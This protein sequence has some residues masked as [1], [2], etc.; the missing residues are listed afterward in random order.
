MLKRL[1]RIL[2]LVLS[3]VA[4]LLLFLNLLL[5]FPSIQ[6][7]L[8]HRAASYLSA[9]LHAKVQVGKVDFEFL[10]KL[11]L[12]DVYV[13]DLHKDTLLY[14]DA[15]RVD[16]GGLDF[17]KH[18]LI[19]SDLI[20][21]NT[22]FKV[23]TYKGERY[24]NIQF[25][26]DFFASKDTTTKAPGPKWDPK[27]NALTL[28]N[29]YFS[30]R[31][32]YLP[33]SDSL[34]DGAFNPGDM[35]IHNINGRF[36]DIQFQGDTLRG[37][38]ERLAAR[39]ESGLTLKNLNCYVKLSSRKMELDA[40]K[41]ETPKSTLI[42]DL[43]FNYRKFP[44]F[45]DFLNKVDMN[46]SFHESTLSFE[47]L[48]IFAPALKGVHN[49]FIIS[50]DYLG[51][52]SHLIGHNMKISWGKFSSFEGDA[53][54]V[55]LPDIMKT[56]IDVDVDRLV[57][58]KSELEFLPRPPF[59][60]TDHISLPDNFACLK[61]VQLSGSFKGYVYDF[62]ASGSMSSGIGKIFAVLSMKQDT[63]ANSEKVYYKG[64]LGTEAFDLGTFWQSKD[65]GTVTSSVTIEG[66]GLKREN[67]DAQLTGTIES[68]GFKK[69]KYTNLSLSGELRKG[70]FS[71][72][73]GVNDPNLQMN[74]NGNIDIAS[75]VHSYQLNTYISKANLDKLNL[76]HDTIG[77]VRLSTHVELELKGNNVDDMD[78]TIHIDSTKFA[79]HKDNYH[80]KYLD[81]KS[82]HKGETHN[83]TLTSDYADASLSGYFPLTK[84]SECVD[85]M[86][87]PYFPS[88]FNPE[89]RIKANK[90]D[91]HDYSFNIH[92]N[93]NTGLTNLFIPT[94][95]IS[96]GS[97]LKATYKEDNN[98]VAMT[99][100]MALVEWAGKK[101]KHLHMD[102]SG[103]ASK[104][105]INTNCDTLFVGDSVYASAFTIKSVA[106]H[107]TTHYTIKWNNDSGNYADIPGI[108]AFP[109]KTDVIF[110]FMN[111]IID[112][113]DSIWQANSKNIAIIDTSGIIA[114]DLEFY[115]TSQSITIQGKLS[116]QKN[117]AMVVIFK[118]LNLED[119]YAGTT[120]QIKGTVD[121]TASVANVYAQHPF[122]AG[123]L[124]FNNFAFNKQA[125]GD[126]SINCYWDNNSQAISLN[127]QI[128][129]GD[130]KLLSFI[131]YYY[132]R[133]TNNLH[134]DA[135]MQDVPAKIFQPYLKDYTSDFDGSISGNAQINGN[136]NKPLFS[137]DLTVNVK[138]FK[139]DYL[140]TYYHATA[141]NVAVTPDTFLIKP[142]AVLD[143]R[144][145]TAI[146]S[147]TITHTHFKNFK[148][149]L[150][151][152][153]RN[154]LCLNTTEANNNLYYGKGFA[155]GNV[156][157][158]GPLSNIH[159]DAGITTEKGTAFNI[160]LS[161]AQE[162]DESDVIRFVNK[163]EHA[164]QKKQTSR[165]DLGG[166]QMHFTVKVTDD[167]TAR[168]IFAEKIGDVMQGTGHG[169]LQMDM[170]TLGDFSIRGEYTVD[171]G[172]YDFTMKN[173]FSKKFS[174]ENGGT[175]NWTGDPYN[176]D[177]D[178]NAIYKLRTSLSPLFPDD[179]TG[180][181][182]KTFPV[183]CDMSLTGKLTSPNIKF[184]VDLPT[185]DE[186]TRGIV[187]GYLNTNDEMFRQV[188]ALLV[189]KSFMPIQGGGTGSPNP[190]QALGINSTEF[191]SDQL[192]NIL[193]SI[194]NKVN[195]GV[196]YQ[197]GT[198]PNSQELQLMFSTQLFNDR[199]AI[200]G[201]AGTLGG[202]TGNT[203]NV[204]TNN[205]MGEVTVEYKLSKDGKVRV[206]A[207]N[208]AN[209]NTTIL[210]QNTPYTQGGGIA[211]KTSFNK[212]GDLF[213]KSKKAK[214]PAKKEQPP[215]ITK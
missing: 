151:I 136:L 121:G 174:I 61:T 141:I 209:D 175:I 156:R 76:I 213:K 198:S 191:I 39:D 81:L 152:D 3:V 183:N 177:I 150:N 41:L 47:D 193:S 71:G 214:S 92:F 72:L 57:T 204:N 181:Y 145:D 194:S 19:V 115:H 70:F 109:N 142:S 201:D 122:F 98:E 172:I 120:T 5:R 9:K 127:G 93:E 53:V 97:E 78:G 199:L 25:I 59:D 113:R 135:T 128:N 32:E 101:L 64:S 94:F 139:F 131:G 107:D 105:K 112:L 153:A 58:S 82:S 17:S 73:L 143:D 90:P 22:R 45:Y 212:W 196:N 130:T 167:A 180:V 208:K 149:D 75:Q 163:K 83:I 182:K 4:T 186:G 56:T 31:N 74:F 148:L 200:S 124:S 154:F 166:L 161:T 165:A 207:F 43:V 133:D 176:A 205:V 21:D 140:N 69:Y 6:T 55:G 99:G 14:A 37:I 215:A 24:P 157:I 38:I 66:N 110:K 54:L 79:Y 211:Y 132:D 129:S 11:V 184:G 10:K 67:A 34:K 192:S 147:G 104:L 15:I 189:I 60:K 159:I 170:S 86:L 20:L 27:I 202:T 95:K 116:H 30:F 63:T 100:D 28:N 203:P 49:S 185:V 137:G 7:W 8:T 23:I 114:R 44:D 12:R 50:G 168:L 111:P 162:V 102:A 89:K 106:A 169:T 123:S 158:Y 87:S 190:G 164:T 171:D 1:K 187:N 52:V 16:V 108:I 2:I 77:P 210:L 134:I 40:M 62:H 18:K 42:T 51:T 146:A 26:L 36:D 144:K 126:G 91:Y 29:I 188:M 178:L 88:L 85:N 206:K 173:T 155:S 33:S 197:P 84:I 195:V 65:L 118:K 125:L 96:K 179:S 35:K 48:A 117:D 103:D 160:P 119:F 46:A 68:F 80:V 138:K 13:E